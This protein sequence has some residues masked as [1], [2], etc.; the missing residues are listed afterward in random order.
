M[1]DAARATFIRANTTVQACRIAPEIRLHLADK[2]VPIWHKTEEELAAEGL[3]PPFW[4]F[5]WAGGQALARHILD[6]PK[7]V[8]AQRVLDFA[9]GCGVGAIAAVMAGAADVTAAEIDPFACAACRINAELN[10]VQI[11]V[12]DENQIGRDG[13]WD[14]IL[15]GD[16]LYEQPTAR[17]VETWL[18][19]QAA[20]GVDVLVGDPGRAYLPKSGLDELALYEVETVLELEDQALKR[21]RVYRL[22][23]TFG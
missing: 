13:P 17:R 8:R 5:A 23:A 19:A 12:T 1:D 9:A 10:G 20:Q 3:P 16:I 14:V 18:A 2:L 22:P 15:A 21:S 6:H 4:A 11:T 7:L